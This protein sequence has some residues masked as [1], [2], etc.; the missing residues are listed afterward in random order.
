MRRNV[1]SAHKMSHNLT[2]KSILKGI[3]ATTRILKGS[4]PLVSPLVPAARS[5]NFVK[6][7]TYDNALSDFLSV[8][9]ANVRN[10]GGPEGVRN[11]NCLK[12]TTQC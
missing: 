3:T 1:Q 2:G 11:Y 4:T 7:G 8:K 6:P 5:S 9:P 12:K 10:Y